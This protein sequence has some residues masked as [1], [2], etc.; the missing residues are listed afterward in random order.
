MSGDRGRGKGMVAQAINQC[1]NRH[2]GPLVVANYGAIP[3][4]LVPLG[5]ARDYQAKIILGLLRVDATHLRL[6]VPL[7]LSLFM[8]W[9]DI[10]SKRIPNYL[11][12]GSAL[13]GWG[14]QLGFYGLPG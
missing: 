12:L 6:L 11:T 1:G 2:D 4:E 3:R 14:F 5:T 9:T 7:A 10:Q 13:P 8:A